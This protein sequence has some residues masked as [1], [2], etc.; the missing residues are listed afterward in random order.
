MNFNDLEAPMHSPQWPWPIAESLLKCFCFFSLYIIVGGAQSN[1]IRRDR[2]RQR[3]PT[4]NQSTEFHLPSSHELPGKIPAKVTASAI[5]GKKTRLISLRPKIQS[6][7]SQI[8]FSR[9]FGFLF[10]QRTWKHFRNFDLNEN[11]VQAHT[12]VGK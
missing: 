10:S 2:D 5:E 6:E 7:K 4:Q 3:Q 1:W 8:H 12:H 11:D 9:D